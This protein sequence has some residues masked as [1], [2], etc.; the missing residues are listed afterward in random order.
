MSTQDNPGTRQLLS[1]AASRAE[2]DAQARDHDLAED[3]HAGLLASELSLH[4][5]PISSSRSGGVVGVEALIRWNSARRGSVSP[6]IFIP[7][8]ERSGLIHEIG[9]WVLD[10]ACLQLARWDRIGLIF[11][12]VAV[13]VSPEQIR[14]EN[15]LS[16]VDTAIEASGI[17]PSRLVLEITEDRPIR[18]SE[19]ARVL[20]EAIRARGI[21]LAVDDFGVGYSTLTYLA[22]LPVSKVKIDRSFVTNLTTSRN[23]AAIISALVGLA[24]TLNL[25][26]VAEGVE[27]QAQLDLLM[28]MGCDHIQGWFVCQP[29]PSDELAQ[30]FASQS[31]RLHSEIA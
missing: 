9:R 15:L 3:L 16:H 2:A 11:P 10:T 29:L 8:A 18:D 26:L 7:V 23:D 4:Y 31:L 27:T 1:S 22:S 13:N 25:D 28:E 17:D 14:S 5:Q 12:F 20:C 24:R 19:A 30:R 21:G 6:V